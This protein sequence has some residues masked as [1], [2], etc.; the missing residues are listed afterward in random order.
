M[1]PCAALALACWL[2]F[3]LLAPARALEEA[4]PRTD[5]GTAAQAPLLASVARAAPVPHAQGRLF[6]LRRP[7]AA[8]PRAAPSWLFGT[9]HSDDP[10]VLRLSPVVAD[11]L[12]GADTLVLE[13]VPD[14]A[15]MQTA[16][17]AMRL[18]DNRRLAD[19]LAPALYRRCIAALNAR[20]LPEV[21]VQDLKP[22]AV[23][24][25]LSMPPARTGEFL[26][27]YLYNLAVAA[28]TP[29]LGLETTAEQLALFDALSPVDQRALLRA[30]LATLDE[31]PR[32]LDELM[33]AYLAGDLGTLLALSEAEVP[34]LAHA[35][36]ARFRHA[37]LDARNARMLRRIQALPEAGGY[38]IAVGALHLPGAAGL[39]RG[40]EQAGYAVRPR[41]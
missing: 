36:Q 11:A 3:A 16:A 1:R 17:A 10:R 9:I 19:V 32:K 13:V 31:Q 23:M 18:G 21:A 37:L 27:R 30:T 8:A 40:L 28:E 39:L 5:V 20:G 38:F 29:V 25:L 26:D 2:L 6:E 24:T 12:A 14:A 41:Q 7:D 4:P 22:W 33:D 15:A 34:G 35:L